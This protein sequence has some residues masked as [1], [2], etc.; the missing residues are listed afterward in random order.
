VLILISGFI[1]PSRIPNDED[2]DEEESD[3][4]EF[5]EDERPRGKIGKGKATR[6]PKGD[7]I[8]ITGGDDPETSRVSANWRPTHIFSFE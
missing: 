8:R 4:E 3:E 1:L 5:E 6:A 2:S 7:N